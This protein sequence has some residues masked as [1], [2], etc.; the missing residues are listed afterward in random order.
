MQFLSPSPRLCDGE[1]VETDLNFFFLLA[2]KTMNQNVSCETIIVSLGKCE[3]FILWE[4][5][6]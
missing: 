2:C 4:I 6:H 3:F 5:F 1:V